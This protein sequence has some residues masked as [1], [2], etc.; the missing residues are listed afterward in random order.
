MKKNLIR[1]EALKDLIQE[2]VDK[3]ASNV[4]QIHKT[5]ADLPFTVLEKAGILEEEAKGARK[6]ADRTIGQVYDAIR[7]V[8]KEIGEIATSLFE[9]ADDFNTVDDKL[10]APEAPEASEVP[11][12]K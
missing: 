11:E 10:K 12:E 6:V 3:G 4:E 1:L 2:A 8:N 5:I 9:A 7:A